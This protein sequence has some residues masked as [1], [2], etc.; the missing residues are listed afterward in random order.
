MTWAPSKHQLRMGHAPFRPVFVLFG[1]NPFSS[2]KQHTVWAL[3]KNDQR[4]Q[5]CLLLSRSKPL[6][7]TE[8]MASSRHSIPAL[9]LNIPVTAQRSSSLACPLHSSL[10]N[11]HAFVVTVCSG[12]S[13]SWHL[14]KRWEAACCPWLCEAA[15]RAAKTNTWNHKEADQSSVLCANISIIHPDT[16]TS[17]SKHIQ[18]RLTHPTV[19]LQQDF[20]CPTVPLAAKLSRDL[21]SDPREQDG[22]TEFWTWLTSHTSVWASGFYFYFSKIFS[23]PWS[24]PISHTRFWERS[25]SKRIKS[26]MWFPSFGFD[27]YSPGVKFLPLWKPYLSCI[28][29]MEYRSPNFTPEETHICWEKSLS[30]SWETSWSRRNTC[31][32]QPQNPTLSHFKSEMLQLNHAVSIL[33]E[34]IYPGKRETIPSS[35]SV[36]IEVE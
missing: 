33:S 7:L 19:I 2:Y 17:E 18:A 8:S 16:P 11:H 36:S 23:L 1:W 24:K 26:Y 30:D 25:E 14:L 35:K 6:L 4:S 34:K 13:G 27:Y 32:P 15:I 22:V 9:P 10:Q 3:L 29:S 5:R 12:H 21:L 28:P 20:P 31:S